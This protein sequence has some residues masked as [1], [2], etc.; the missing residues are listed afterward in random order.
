MEMPNKRTNENWPS[1]LVATQL[2]I[3][4]FFEN[5]LGITAVINGNALSVQEYLKYVL[6]KRAFGPIYLH[7]FCLFLSEKSL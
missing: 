1:C 7:R 5:D 3:L 4:N 6:K 2:R